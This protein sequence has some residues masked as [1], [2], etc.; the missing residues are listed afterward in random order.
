MNVHEAMVKESLEKEGYFV[1]TNFNVHYGKNKWKEADIVAIRKNKP[2]I[3]GEVKGTY[4]K[5]GS[6]K[7]WS[8]EQIAK[9]I[10]FSEGAMDKFKEE[11]GNNV[12]CIF[13]CTHKPDK[14]IIDDFKQKHVE[15]E[16]FKDVV[17]KLINAANSHP[18]RYEPTA[19]LPHL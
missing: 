3:I 5:F 11:F 4:H 17:D 6:N 15:I 13:Y 8:K 1:Q 10:F 16:T 9:F 7:K 12:K 18:K 19:H 14:T 2:T